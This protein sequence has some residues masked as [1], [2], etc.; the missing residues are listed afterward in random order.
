MKQWLDDSCVHLTASVCK[1]LQYFNRM[2]ES[3]SV[4]FTISSILRSGL[5]IFQFENW[6]LVKVESRDRANPSGDARRLLISSRV[7][8]TV[9]Y[10]I[11]WVLQRHAKKWNGMWT[12]LL[13]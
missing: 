6:T 13:I 7:T 10:P 1:H 3:W 12:F 11:K 8:R 9:L 4:S 2:Y 5:N